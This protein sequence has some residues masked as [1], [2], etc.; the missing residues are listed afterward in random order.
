MKINQISSPNIGS[1][2]IRV[3]ISK[4]WK[5]DPNKNPGSFHY[6]E[7]MLGSYFGLYDH[8]KYFYNLNGE[9]TYD[10][11]YIYKIIELGEEE[12]IINKI[13]QFIMA[14]S[15]NKDI[16]ENEKYMVHNEH[17]VKLDKY[18]PMKFVSI[19]DQV[20]YNKLHAIV[21]NLHS[22]DSSVI[23]DIKNSLKGSDYIISFVN[24]QNINKYIKQFNKV[25][26]NPLPI[27]F[28]KQTPKEMQGRYIVKVYSHLKN[29]S[30]FFIENVDEGFCHI[31]AY[32]TKLFKFNGLMFNIGIYE[33]TTLYIITDNFTKPIK[34]TNELA[35]MYIESFLFYIQNILTLESIID[36]ITY[37]ELIDFYMLT[38]KKSLKSFIDFVIEYPTPIFTFNDF[39]LFICDDHD[40]N[41]K[42]YNLDSKLYYN[43]ELFD[44]PLKINYNINQPVLKQTPLCI[45]IDYQKNAIFSNFMIDVI[46]NIFL[47]IQL[48][49]QMI[50]GFF[51]FF[52]LS[53]MIFNTGMIYSFNT[54][55]TNI[56]ND[57]DLEIV[58]SNIN[59]ISYKNIANIIKNMKNGIT[60]KYNNKNYLFY[61]IDLYLQNVG[62]INMNNRKVIKDFKSELNVFELSKYVITSEI[63]KNI[64]YIDI[65]YYKLFDQKVVPD[66]FTIIKGKSSDIILSFVYFQYIQTLMHYL[67]SKRR[68]YT[69][70]IPASIGFNYYIFFL[71]VPIP[72]FID[73]IKE[74]LAGMNDIFSDIEFVPDISLIINGFIKIM[75]FNEISFYTIDTDLLNNDKYIKSNIEK[76]IHESIIK[77]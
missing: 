52:I 18:M 8:V 12:F 63:K 16:L 19:Y 36:N 17:M 53:E 51:L 71:N 38:K 9:T 41:K 5:D 70:S 23:V 48:H 37:S 27:K 76:F 77:A 69:Y 50:V 39:I 75:I 25:I 55:V 35:L 30:M 65:D 73:V 29:S 54:F 67:I 72:N 28:E 60:D 34:S 49:P 26:F 10:Y 6:L 20:K 57:S 13:L 3:T 59:I 40:K 11:L 66:K 64:K 68:I 56:Y 33:S 1:K 62:E 31:I 45:M 42:I 22:L 44:G 61:L 32:S 46:S 15:F 58:K 24:F 47:K 43:V 7:H 74:E 14:K 2:V 21:G 4:G